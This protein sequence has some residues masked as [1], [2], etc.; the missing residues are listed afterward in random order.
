MNLEKEL[1][2]RIAGEIVLS[3]EPGRTIK[4]WREIFRLSQKELAG[5]LGMSV[6]VISDYEN[7]RRKSPGAAMI[8]K[9]VEALIEFDAQRGRE[10][11]KRFENIYKGKKDSAILDIR[12]FLT[13]IKCREIADVLECEIVANE[14]LLDRF[15]YGY[16]V[17]DSLKAILEMRSDEF[18]KLYGLTSQRA[19]VFTKVKIGRSPFIAIKVAPIKPA[20]VI[21]N[22]PKNVDKLG[23]EIA[24]RERIPVAVTRLS[25]RKIID[26]LRGV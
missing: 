14:D 11:L 20:F 1:A 23:I 13:P 15:I 21:L 16:T 8:R 6:S 4:K 3:K 7:G 17:V 25:V 26:R 18:I 24:K 2:T 12:D 19:I 9:I 22:K 10:I 5:L